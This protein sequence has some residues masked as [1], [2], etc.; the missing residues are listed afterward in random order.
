MKKR[1][2]A[3]SL[4]AVLF[5]LV[6]TAIIL[7][8]YEKTKIKEDGFNMYEKTA[9]FSSNDYIN[10]T[11]GV[12]N[13]RLI[14]F[15][16]NIEDAVFAFQKN[17]TN[18]N[19]LLYK[20]EEF[21]LKRIEDEEGIL[22]EGIILGCANNNYFFALDFLNLEEEELS[23]KLI[24]YDFESD[25]I[26]AFKEISVNWGDLQ[27]NNNETE[28]IWPI[29]DIQCDENYIY[30]C[31]KRKAST[32]LVYDFEL[33]L[34]GLEETDNTW[35][36]FPNNNSCLILK[37]G[38]TIMQFSKK[39]VLEEIS[40]S[41][42]FPKQVSLDNMKIYPGN[43][44]YDFFFQVPDNSY[45]NEKEKKYTGILYGIEKGGKNTR[46]LFS[47]EQMGLKSNSI[48]SVISSDE[49][50]FIVDQIN[51]YNGNDEYFYL[52]K[53][54]E[55][56][57]ESIDKNR[58]KLTIGGL[59]DSP[60][61]QR[62][63]SAYNIS[64]DKYYIEYKNYN[65]SDNYQEGI[66]KLNIDIISN[67]NIDAIYLQGLDIEDLKK[68]GVLA[69]LDD[70]FLQSNVVSED[71]FVD[72]AYN[73]MKN[74]NESV[75]SVFTEM[76]F[77]GI[78]SKEKID[79]KG[80]ADYKQENNCIIVFDLFDDPETQFMQ[81]IK[82]SGDKYIDINNQKMNLDGDFKELMIY[83]KE[84]EKIIKKYGYESGN[85]MIKE[86]NA[87]SKYSSMPFPYSYFYIKFL[88]DADPSCQNIAID[89]PI[90]IPENEMG[91]LEN[92]T[93][94]DIFYDFLDFVFD[95][96]NYQQF[97]GNMYFPVK[98]EAWKDW[99]KRLSATEDYENRFG[100]TIYAVD[101]Y[102]SENGVST[103]LPPVKKEDIQKMN[104]FYE[105]AEIVR[106]LPNKYLTIISEEIQYYY[107]G[108][109]SAEN[110]CK[111]IEERVWLA[112]NE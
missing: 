105:Q 89:A 96:S 37:D 62:A 67:C 81:M 8:Y 51:D 32:L 110:V 82:Y 64:N 43:S 24:V 77:E 101:F 84:E 106:P 6:F 80:I 59:F 47:F 40:Y 17:E 85:R 56:H 1:I 38:K 31:T 112:L 53:S 97:F 20:F 25:D 58:K 23:E 76:S 87:H 60:S 65:T 30:I 92:S 13:N 88:V 14:V 45:L 42:K 86:G 70:Y 79:F 108:N 2:I 22:S 48:V 102:Y 78:V 74:E 57:D 73:N 109:E 104:E 75:Y 15:G 5:V 90:L 44:Y 12:G 18:S 26:S 36:L 27:E 66:E 9:I 68:K 16:N 11:E 83:L 72:L 55:V 39:G 10:E 33:N 103:M 46:K 95:D 111:K 52:K 93:Q 94:K 35:K 4:I 63:I 99:E 50:D 107:N 3:I 29:E 54:S 69:N 100:E 98:K 61:L 49:G 19:N 21:E 41:L 91:L 28:F 34:V 71:E 7:S